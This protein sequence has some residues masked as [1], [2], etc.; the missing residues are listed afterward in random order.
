MTNPI[1]TE[2]KLQN[3]MDDIDDRLE[4]LSQRSGIAHFNRLTGEE[5]E[6]LGEL[7]RL[8]A[9]ILLDENN[10]EIIRKWEGRVTDPKMKTRLNHFA[11]AFLGARIQ[12]DP[13]LFKMSNPLE[14]TIVRFQPEIN[15]EKISRSDMGRIL[16]SDP[17][18]ERRREAY[19]AGKELDA[20]ISDDVADLFEKRNE[21]ARKLGYDDY[22]SLG[23]HLQDLKEHEL[24]ALFDR[25]E[26]MTNETW[27]QLIEEAR[28]ALQVEDL[29]PWDLSYYLNSVHP[30]PSSDLFKKDGIIPCVKRSVARC[31][32]DLDA[33]PI[34]IYEKD[35]PYG[36]LC[37]SIEFGKDVRILANPRDGHQWYDILLHETGHGIQSSLLDHSSHIVAGGDPPFF[38]EGIAGIY[39]RIIHEPVVLKDEFSL[40]DEDIANLVRITRFKRI[41][42]FRGIMVN[43][44]LEWAVYHGE[45]DPETLMRELVRRY[46]HMDIPDE[47]RG[48]AGNT[49]YT[50]HPLYSQNYM[51]ME[52][53]ALQTIEAARE[54]FNAFPSTEI[55]E[56]VRDHYIKDAGWTP[57]REKIVSATGSELS[58]NALIRYLSHS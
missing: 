5:H 4:T 34:R 35:I 22:V 52:V 45:K 48:W 25:V 13:E 32:G 54:K 8:S 15:G 23:F 12:N 1:D 57:W 18:R 56:F 29:E 37:M 11:R 16:E 31:G 26:K 20:R 27:E 40:S 53:M 47:C 24:T 19:M 28:T 36:G 58:A 46:L 17:S 10:R 33:L 7:N 50:T 6:D 9:E 2:K 51:L 42:W 3:F 49:L 55:F 30:S 44:R 38:W 43:C 39:E 41:Q 14:E 21:L